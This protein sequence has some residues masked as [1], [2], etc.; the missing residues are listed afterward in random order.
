MTRSK[1]SLPYS[2]V[3]TAAVFALSAGVA[4]P[5]LVA[6]PAASA[7]AADVSRVATLDG[8][9]L[10]VGLPYNTLWV[11]VSVLASSAPDAAVLVSTDQ[12]VQKENWGSLWST[13]E[14][15]RLPEGTAY[16]DYPVRVEYRISGGPARTWNG[17]T[18]GYRLH[19]GVSELSFDRPGTDYDN[20]AAV[21]SGAATTYDPVTGTTAP[22]RAGTKVKVVLR[23]TS[24]TWWDARN[25]TVT[26]VTGDGGTFR[27][28]VTLNGEVRDGTAEVTEPAADTDPL[29]ARPVPVLTADWTRYRVEAR[30]DKRRVHAGQ[31]VKVTGRVERLTDEGW[32]PFAGAQMLSATSPPDEREHTVSGLMGKGT[33]AADGT[34]SY[35]AKAVHSGSVHTFVKPSGYFAKLPADASEIAVPQ[36]AT[37][38]GVKIALDP[39]GEVKATGKFTGPNCN[40]DTVTLQHS[41]DGRN[42]YNLRHAKP[43]FDDHNRCSFD[44]RT[45]GYVSAFYRVHHAESDRLLAV[46]SPAIHQARKP[47][48]FTGA[49]FSPTRP[50]LNTN[51]TASGTLQRQVNGKWQPYSGAKL[52]VLFR[53]KGESE[54]YWVVKGKSGSG[55][56]YKLKGKVYGDGHWA[57]VT[58]PANGYFYNE[59]KVTYINAR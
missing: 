31:P 47:V 18:F 50:S 4:A 21:L 33:A 59:T 26:A 37:L 51:L 40:Y 11:K 53:F 56:K 43:Q 32:Q 5:V 36:K 54:W 2:L 24:P 14:P 10:E 23:T 17:G 8:G 46:A 41:F 58:E 9:R 57:V 52:T 34:F 16:G 27:L 3:R 1:R 30:T 55:G 20:P 13:A 12:L 15:L 29:D 49:K 35:T 42:W 6:A 28:P 45:L 25:Q 7:T 38:S 19:T 22:A 48:R 39:F 44:I